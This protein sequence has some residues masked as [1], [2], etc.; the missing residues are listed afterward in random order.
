MPEKKRT[1]S[2]PVKE[3]TRCELVA[4]GCLAKRKN[5]R[6]YTTKIEKIARHPMVFTMQKKVPASMC[7]KG[8]FGRLAGKSARQKTGNMT[9]YSFFLERQRRV[10]QKP[11]KK[12]EQ[13]LRTLTGTP[14][15]PDHE[16][17]YLIKRHSPFLS[18]VSGTR[19]I[20]EGCP[21]QGREALPSRRRLAARGRFARSGLGLSVVRW[22]RPAALTPSV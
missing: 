9:R 6:F 10:L 16:L 13:P 22:R 7:V 4:P 5:L 1:E 3:R 11:R 19:Y 17:G 8:P 2:S 18:G 21:R 15:A 20:S 14:R 12:H